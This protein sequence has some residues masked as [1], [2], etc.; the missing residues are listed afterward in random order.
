MHEDEIL[1]ILEDVR[2]P[3]SIAEVREA[4]EAR[5]GGR[6]PY[7]TTKRDLL[8]LSAKGLIRSKSIGGGKR[9]TW[10]FWALRQRRIRAES[11]AGG[12]DAFN[13]PAARRDSMRPEEL[14]ALYDRLVEEHGELIREQLRGGSRYVILCDGKVVR[15]SSNEPSD[16]EV[17]DLEARY[18]KVCYVLTEDPIEEA[19]W[20]PVGNGDY[21]PTIGVLVGGVEW[22]EGDVF[23]RGL[24][25]NP[26]FD[27]G[28]PDV[29]AFSAEEL[30]PIQPMRG[31]ILRRAFHLGR[32]YDYYLVPLRIGVIDAAGA[33]RCVRKACRAVLSWAEPERNPFLLANPSRRGFVG[34]DLML[35]FPLRIVLSG[36]DKESSVLLE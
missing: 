32:H 1:S 14:T 2:R 23:D 34:R 27:T 36:R 7:E 30:D 17:R 28:N 19:P 26:D 35:T 29:A 25:I 6:V 21:Y 9:V 10:V 15:T 13:V 33:R 18:G 22:R 3:L 8:A 5:L 20:S 24:R 4:L 16:E 11:P 12:V 31:R